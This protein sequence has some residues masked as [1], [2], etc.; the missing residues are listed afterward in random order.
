MHYYVDT[1]PPIETYA[2]SMRGGRAFPTLLRPG[3]LTYPS[4]QL[5]EDND[6][7]LDVFSVLKGSRAPT[8]DPLAVRPSIG[9]ITRTVAEATSQNVS[10]PENVRASTEIE[11][12]VRQRVKL[13]AAKYAGGANS[14][15]VVARLEIL[16]HRLLE[17]SP[18]I[19]HEQVEALE[20]AN[21]QLNKVR[22][23]R[24]QRAA[25]LGLPNQL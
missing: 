7:A 11:T 9:T 19:S 18:R 15:E 5:A 16:G 6:R 21:E 17:R 24:E 3:Y 4:T 14:A 8:A 10:L 12:M 23:A 22:V 25:R 20:L 2:E 1:N 13:M